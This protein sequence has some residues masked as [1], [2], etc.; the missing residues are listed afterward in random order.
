MKLRRTTRRRRV[1]IVT[2]ALALAAGVTVP[3]LASAG[4]ISEAA[5]FE[6]DD[7]DLDSQVDTDWNDFD[8]VTWTGTAP[9]QQG[10][11]SADG[12]SLFGLT[13]AIV[14]TSDTA[15]AG[16]VKQDDFC[17]VT[18]G[19]KAPNK[20]DLVEVYLATKTIDGDV[21]LALS[22]VRIPQNSTSAS[23]H[24]AFE[25]N[26]GE[27]ALRADHAT[28]PGS[29]RGTRA[30]GRVDRVRLRGRRQ[31]PD[32]EA[33]TLAGGFRRRVEHRLRL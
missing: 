11:S 31:R 14:S 26:Q 25:F 13:D 30:G 20:D 9:Y 3:Y 16:G 12:W 1:A 19:A 18:K 10:E 29:A 2:A 8:P 6:G 7:G 33:V 23:A 15:F 28:P 24:V 32:V 21:H 22:W 27:T 4:P 17:A 5:D